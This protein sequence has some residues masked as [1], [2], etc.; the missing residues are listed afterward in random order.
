MVSFM[1]PPGLPSST[2]LSVSFLN[3]VE[4]RGISGAD[5]RPWWALAY[6]A[7]SLTVEQLR[8]PVDNVAAQASSLV[9]AMDVVLSGV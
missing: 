5:I 4:A 2:A 1:T 8:R 7:A 3:L 9:A 6:Y